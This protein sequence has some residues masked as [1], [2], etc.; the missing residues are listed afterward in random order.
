ME[1]L[2]FII[3][4]PY[5]SGVT[6]SSCIKGGE[7][8]SFGKIINANVYISLGHWFVSKYSYR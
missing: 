5:D 1:L 2:F 7:V 8:L 3:C 6:Y 4:V